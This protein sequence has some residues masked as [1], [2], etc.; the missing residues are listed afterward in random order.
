MGHCQGHQ[1]CPRYC[2]KK[3]KIKCLWRLIHI[4]KKTFSE[5][6][7]IRGFPIH[8][9]FG[10]RAAGLQAVTR[11]Q[12]FVRSFRT[13]ENVEKKTDKK[14]LSVVKC[15]SVGLKGIKGLQSF[16]ICYY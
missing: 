5:E 3:D 9:Q 10:C 16:R 14:L 13:E 7:K 1:D 12:G 15:L 11:M 2:D 6:G 8:N 4:D